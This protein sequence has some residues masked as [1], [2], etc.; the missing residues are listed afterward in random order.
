MSYSSL[1]NWLWAQE[2]KI[3]SIY[4][5][6]HEQETIRIGCAKIQEGL[7]PLAILIQRVSEM[8]NS[9]WTLVKRIRRHGREWNLSWAECGSN[10]QRKGSGYEIWKHEIG[11]LERR[12]LE[13]WTRENL[14]TLVRKPN[15]HPL[16]LINTFVL[17]TRGQGEIMGN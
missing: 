4:T 12:V 8:T 16:V 1:A 3:G 17:Y 10:D 11:W 14:S 9:D 15:L 13:G 5:L 6:R 2:I 7:T